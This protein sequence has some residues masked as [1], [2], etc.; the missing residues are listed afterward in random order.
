M[1]RQVA[2]KVSARRIED[3]PRIVQLH[4]YDLTSIQCISYFIIEKLNMRRLYKVQFDRK[5]CI[6]LQYS[7]VGYANNLLQFLQ[8]ILSSGKG[9]ILREAYLRSIWLGCPFFCAPPFAVCTHNYPD[10]SSKGYPMATCRHPIFCRSY[11]CKAREE[12]AYSAGGGASLHPLFRRSPF[13]TVSKPAFFAILLKAIAVSPGFGIFGRQFVLTACR[14][15]LLNPLDDHRGR[16]QILPELPE[17]H[18]MAS[19][20]N[21]RATSARSFPSCEFVCRLDHTAVIALLRGIHW[22]PGWSCTITIAYT[23]PAAT[24]RPIL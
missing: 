2:R 16:T 21:I 20:A 6:A 24:L 15:E 19:F 12:A 22:R 8:H 7:Q 9:R 3:S 23:T 13:F 18:I 1:P 5:A 11:S 10:E 17:V 14:A 4:Y